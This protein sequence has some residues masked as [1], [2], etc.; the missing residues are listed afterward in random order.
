MRSSA[1]D[2]HTMERGQVDTRNEKEALTESL[3]KICKLAAQY[4]T[5]V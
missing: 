5:K 4:W 2:S 3:E 1:Q